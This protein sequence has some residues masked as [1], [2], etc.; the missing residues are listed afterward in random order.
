MDLL[1]LRSSHQRCSI[2]KGILK[3]FVKFTRKHLSQSLFFDEI[4]GLRPQEFSYESCE[5]FKNTSFTKHLWT[6]ASVRWASWNINYLGLINRNNQCLP[7]FT[8]CISA[9]YNLIDRPNLIAETKEKQLS[10]VALQ[11]SFYKKH[12]WRR[13]AFLKTSVINSSF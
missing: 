13:K 10:P 1:T 8:Y 5:I 6:T 2:K 7:M 12:R 4:A 3:N 11:N 9:Y